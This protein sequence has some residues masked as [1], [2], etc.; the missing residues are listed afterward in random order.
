MPKNKSILIVS[1]EP[2]GDLHASNL[3]GDLKSIDP[4]L[5]FFGMGGA[6]SRRSGVDTAFDISEL[7]L[8]GVVEVAGHI[9]TV[10]RAFRAVVSALDREKPDLAILVDY[11]GFNL[12]LAKELKRR[13]I[14]IVY[15]ISPQVWAWGA[16]RI[17]TISQCVR[18]ILVFFRFEE[19]L[20]KKNG[21]DAMFVGNPLIDTVR[22]TSSKQ[23]TLKKYG[24]ESGK[25]V[26]AL[27]PGSRKL[28]VE[29]FLRVMVA[30]A[31]LMKKSCSDLC[32]VVTRHPDLP[33]ELYK[34]A[35][36]G[37][38][39]DINVVT[40]DMYNIV[41]ASDI[42]IVASGTATLETAIIGTPQ[43]IVYKVNLLTYMLYKIVRPAGF[44]GLPNIISGGQ[45]VPEL[46]Q[47]D[48]TPENIARQSLAILSDGKL[49][50][51]IRADLAYVKSSLGEPGASMRAA[52][53]ILPLLR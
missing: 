24:I 35:L 7:A 19:E 21:V 42:A 10:G 4:S 23:D 49:A 22:L 32:F 1:G 26:V 44:L 46:L 17:K 18:K 40:G 8:V 38:D 50:D 16:D 45:V 43:V 3:V 6:L 29:K 47:Y 33:E 11:P 37:S 9:F 36:T 27:V 53:S 13:N 52:R 15:Y 51:R 2:S 28:E 30:A 14:P 25:R 5:R 20:Y 12:R 39:S 48:M 31:G 34:R 41:G